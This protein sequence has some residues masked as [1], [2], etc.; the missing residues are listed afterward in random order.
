MQLEDIDLA[1]WIGRSETAADT[2]TP[3]PVRALAATLDHTVAPVPDGGGG[4]GVGGGL[5]PADPGR[6]VDVLELHIRTPP[7]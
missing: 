3:T 6:Q 5:A 1:T 4:D 7:R 2:V